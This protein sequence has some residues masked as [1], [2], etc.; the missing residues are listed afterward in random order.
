MQRLAARMLAEDLGRFWPRTAGQ[1]IGD[2]VRRFPGQTRQ[3][4]ENHSPPPSP[5]APRSRTMKP[6][7]PVLVRFTYMLAMPTLLGTGGSGY[8]E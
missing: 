8:K 2:G 6:P 5:T 7:H 1:G 4:Y 3:A